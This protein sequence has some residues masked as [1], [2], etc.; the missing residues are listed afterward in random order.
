MTA[1]KREGIAPGQARLAINSIGE[2][3]DFRLSRAGDKYVYRL[4]AAHKLEML[5][6][7]RNQ[8]IYETNLGEDNKFHARLVDPNEIPA[9]RDERIHPPQTEGAY[10]E[11]DVERPAALGAEPPAQTDQPTL[12]MDPFMPPLGDD[13]RP[14]DDF[15]PA[16]APVQPIDEALANRPS[17]DDVPEAPQPSLVGQDVVTPPAPTDIDNV[18]P[19]PQ[20][21]DNDQPIGQASLDAIQLEPQT[22]FEQTPSIL[23]LAMDP[24]QLDNAQ[25]NVLPQLQPGQEPRIIPLPNPKHTVRADSTKSYSPFSLALACIGF[26]ALIASI[27][28]TVWPAWR[29]RQH[30]KN[31][32]LTIEDDIAI[33]RHQRLALVSRKNHTYLVAVSN[34]GIKL[35]TSCDDDDESLRAWTFFKQK[36]YWHQLADRQMSDKQLNELIQ[37]FENAENAREDA[38][39]NTDEHDKPTLN[40]CP[41][42][43][44]SSTPTLQGGMMT[45][46]KP[47]ESLEFQQNTAER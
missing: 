38:Q 24:E 33:A 8:H 4:N 9:P 37:S 21:V 18:V 32:G 29:A 6:Y 34:K 17:P 16:D 14:D 44:A 42:L 1:L 30:I 27:L 2:V 26:L 3:F 28:I 7:Q 31:A 11:V 40:N 35:L 23:D 39:Q 45:L 25:I 46:D 5:R 10:E 20:P 12:P 13:V 36:T 22:G 19:S 41:Q 15:A 47:R 43:L